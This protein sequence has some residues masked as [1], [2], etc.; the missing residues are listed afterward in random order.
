[1][2]RVSPTDNSRY[3]RGMRPSG[4]SEHRPRWLKAV[5]IVVGVVVILLFIALHL[6]GALGPGA[7]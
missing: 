3:N 4:G 5:A 2:L 7:H 6:S 1:L